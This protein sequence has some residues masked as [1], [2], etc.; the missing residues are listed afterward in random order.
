MC[1]VLFLI[2]ENNYFG[3]IGVSRSFAA[4]S[5]V[6]VNGYFQR[7]VLQNAIWRDL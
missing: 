1:Y 5:V 7:S 6:N 4:K 3:L 2:Q